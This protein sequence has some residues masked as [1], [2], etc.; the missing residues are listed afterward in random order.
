M[1]DL[2]YIGAVVKILEPPKKKLINSKTLVIQC[3]V[4][5]P[6]VRKNNKTKGRVIKLMAWGNLAHA[7]LNY[8][9]VNDYVLVE[10]YSSLR[11]NTRPNIKNKY[12]KQ[13]VITAFKVSPFL[14]SSK[15]LTK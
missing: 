6:Q 5:L 15:S 10:G 12:F 11:E 2:N 14:L 8:Y 1:K 4:Q 7:I 13:V 3:R 9:K